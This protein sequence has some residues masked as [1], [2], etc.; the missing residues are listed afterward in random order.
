[1]STTNPVAEKI[2]GI[3]ESLELSNGDVAELIGTSPQTVSRWDTG[4]SSPTTDRLRTLLTLSWVAE[5]LSELYTPVEARVWLY[6]P[7]RRLGGHS[8]ADMF[9]AGKTDEVRQLV[10]QMV[11]GAYV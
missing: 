1:M 3:R 8:P 2:R 6:H 9:E 10:D 4:A 7:H 5:E 11:S